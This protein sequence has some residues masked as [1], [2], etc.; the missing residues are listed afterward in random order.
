MRPGR[1]GPAP[2]PPFVPGHEGV[3]LVE[4]VGP[5]VTEHAVCDRVALPWLG[6]ACG[7][8]KYCVTGWETLCESQRNTCYS[9]DGAHAEYAVAAAR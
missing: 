9:I 1:G 2:T 4:K 8:C 6:W 5:G 3:G 7:T